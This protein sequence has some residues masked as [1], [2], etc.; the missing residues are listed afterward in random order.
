MLCRCRSQLDEALVPDRDNSPCHIVLFSWRMNPS[1]FVIEVRHLSSEME[2]SGCDNTDSRI[3]SCR[4]T[5]ARSRGLEV[6]GYSLPLTMIFLNCCIATHFILQ[7]MPFA[8]S[9]VDRP[10]SSKVSSTWE[11]CIASH[12]SFTCFRHMAPPHVL[13]LAYAR[14]KN[15]FGRCGNSPAKFSHFYC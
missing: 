7:Y 9:S 11:P 8:A 15:E 2:Q 1:R 14:L 13:T 10:C 6:F 3:E 5:M 12:P 4:C